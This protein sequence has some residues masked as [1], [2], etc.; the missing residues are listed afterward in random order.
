MDNSYNTEKSDT[1]IM[2]AEWRFL[3]NDPKPGRILNLSNSKLSEIICRI[4]QTTVTEKN[5]KLAGFDLVVI[6][7]PDDDDISYA[8]SALKPGSACLLEWTPNVYYKSSSVEARLENAGFIMIDHF[9]PK[10]NPEKE[11]PKI[12]IPLKSEAALQYVFNRGYSRNRSVFWR[13]GF[14][15][16]RIIWDMA[17]AMFRKLPWLVSFGSGKVK[18]YTMAWKPGNPGDAADTR[19]LKEKLLDMKVLAERNDNAKVD[20]LGILIISAGRHMLNKVILVVFND[21]SNSP[22]YIIKIPRIRTSELSLRNEAH[23]L[24]VLNSHDN[25]IHGIPKILFSNGELGYHAVGETVINGEP[26]ANK[27]N[28]RNSEALAKNVTEWLSEL[29][30]KT[31]VAINEEWRK[32]YL[33]Y[34]GEEF[35]L[36]VCQFDKKHSIEKIFKSLEIPCLVCEHRDCAPWNIFISPDKD[37]C[38]LDWESSRLR[39][40]PG[41]DFIYFFTYMCIYLQ[42]AWTTEEAFRCYK[43]MQNADT[44]VGRLFNECFTKYSAK[45][46]LPPE[47]LP[48]L[49]IITWATHLS[50]VMKHESIDNEFESEVEHDTK[51]L[52]STLLKY[53]LSRLG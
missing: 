53:E 41:L 33:Q 49:R 28:L 14:V 52:Y 42:N 32:N 34:M 27:L 5:P 36:H 38:V 17:P 13:I 19:S 24:N 51:D 35:K 44:S 20:E 30:L 46:G 47:Y 31:A 7:D 50:E 11:I 1:F 22:L 21:E 45:I 48:S 16:R 4:N 8:M 6:G 25:P 37:I 9:V 3:L 23:T 15:S 10:P 26:L 12:L 43:E 2:G 29:A 39:G 40:I 18:I